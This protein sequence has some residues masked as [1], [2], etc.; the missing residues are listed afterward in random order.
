MHVV[1]WWTRA[2]YGSHPQLRNFIWVEVH[3]VQEGTKAKVK[4]NIDNEEGDLG[5]YKNKGTYK[6]Q[7]FGSRDYTLHL[8][9]YLG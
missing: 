1:L 7:K 5:N 9:G 3:N 8:I 2:T 4:I 6:A